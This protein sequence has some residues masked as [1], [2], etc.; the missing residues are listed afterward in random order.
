MSAK[1]RG[2]KQFLL[3]A[4]PSGLDSMRIA[5]PELALG[6]IDCRRFAPDF[7]ATSESGFNRL[8]NKHCQ[9]HSTGESSA[10][11]KN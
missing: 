7:K 2:T 3:C 6:A 8:N 5:F 9:T 1:R 11:S 10:V 4:G